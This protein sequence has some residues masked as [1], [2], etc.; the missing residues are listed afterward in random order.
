MLKSEHYRSLFKIQA[1]LEDWIESIKQLNGSQKCTRFNCYR[2]HAMELQIT[3]KYSRL[4]RAQHTALSWSTTRKKNKTQ[5]LHNRSAPTVPDATT[6]IR[7]W[8]LVVVPLL[9]QRDQRNSV[10]SQ[11]LQHPPATIAEPVSCVKP[12]FWLISGKQFRS[13]LFKFVV[14]SE[15]TQQCNQILLIFCEYAVW[16][17]F[18]VFFDRGSQLCMILWLF[19][20]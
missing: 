17:V 8:T 7:T 20:E 13:I 4:I 18:F 16:R 19:L 11:S 5:W 2:C 14:R 1:L 6:R 15:K 12:N 9:P 10:D 3:P